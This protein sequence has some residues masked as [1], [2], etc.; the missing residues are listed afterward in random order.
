[1][2]A[3]AGVIPG[4]VGPPLRGNLPLRVGASM[5]AHSRDARHLP[6]AGRC[7]PMAGVMWR[8]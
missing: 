1:M 3:G 2:V 4:P 5:G 7:V 8:A 6:M